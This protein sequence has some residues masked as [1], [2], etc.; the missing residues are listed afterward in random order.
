[1]VEVVS[2]VIPG[3]DEGGVSNVVGVVRVGV[4]TVARVVVT[5]VTV[6]V[7]VVVTVTVGVV[8]TITQAPYYLLL[9]ELIPSSQ[10]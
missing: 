1:M 2:D 4:I 10:V 7:R 9:G 5:I 8:T 6:T 3:G